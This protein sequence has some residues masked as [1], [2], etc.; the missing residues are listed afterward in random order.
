MPAKSTDRLA[1]EEDEE[2]E[3][4]IQKER[5]AIVVN[6]TIDLLLRPGILCKG[7]IPVIQSVLQ[8]Q[9]HPGPQKRQS[10]FFKGHKN[11]ASR[12]TLLYHALDSMKT[13]HLRNDVITTYLIGST[14]LPSPETQK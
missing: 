9:H 4:L 14:P 12:L 10:L 5:P 8:Q 2:C 1:V 11:T 13:V 6:N 7:H 3:P